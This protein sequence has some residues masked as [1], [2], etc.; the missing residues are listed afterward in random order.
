MIIF[1]LNLPSLVNCHQ[2]YTLIESKNTTRKISK[3]DKWLES[4][5]HEMSF[6]RWCNGS[7]F[8]LEW[9]RCVREREISLNARLVIWKESC[10]HFFL[11]E[12]KQSSSKRSRAYYWQMNRWEEKRIKFTLTPRIKHVKRVMKRIEFN[13]SLYLTLVTCFILSK[14]K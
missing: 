13:C 7:L 1:L 11:R 12:T 8:S 10:Q 2:S 3:Y 5:R 9:K 6:D 14:S 4:V